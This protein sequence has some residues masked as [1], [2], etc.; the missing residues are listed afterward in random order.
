[1]ILFGLQILKKVF[2]FTQIRL[3]NTTA[4]L[5]MMTDSAIYEDTSSRNANN[6]NPSTPVTST[7]DF[8]K[9]RPTMGTNST[10]IVV[11]D[12]LMR[13]KQEFNR[14]LADQRE[15]RTEILQLKESLAVKNDEIQRLKIDE[16]H[17]L[18]EMNTSKEQ[19]ER[20]ANKLKVA[21]TELE[22]LKRKSRMSSIT[23]G[24]SVDESV[25]KLEEEMDG[26]QQ[27]YSDA[28]CECDKLHD[29]LKVVQDEKERVD[30]KYREIF[31]KN[32]ELTEMIEKDKEGAKCDDIEAEK[33]K[34]LLKDSQQECYRLKNLYISLSSEKDDLMRELAQIKALDIHKEISELKKRNASLERALQLAEIKCSELTKMLDKEKA[35]CQL[36]IDE[37]HTKYENGL[38]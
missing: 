15:K 1:M 14:C 29:M 4:E 24:S 25:R 28:M 9:R 34:F 16:N 19:A 36:R 3:E 17:A 37:L 33:G 5:E 11:E 13:L 27:K 26:L 38:F 22:S 6:L 18:V 31:E 10:P 7:K 23:N 35:D 12:Q 20:L 30:E 8:L 21:E 32:Q 2:F